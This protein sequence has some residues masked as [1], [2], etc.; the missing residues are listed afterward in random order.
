VKRLHVVR[1]A[2]SPQR[3]H[4]HRHGAVRGEPPIGMRPPR[5]QRWSVHAT[6]LALLASGV[7]WLIA[8]YGM[9]AAGELAAPHPLEPWSLRLHGIAAYAFLLAFGSMSAV[10]VVLGWRARRNRGS[11][12]GFVLAATLLFVTALGLYYGPESAHATTSMLHWGLGLALLPLL[13]LHIVIARRHAR[14]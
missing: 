13:W 8:H 7:A 5:W 11:G 2:P 1:R 10:H 12:A 4:L 14:R 6:V 9:R 3:H